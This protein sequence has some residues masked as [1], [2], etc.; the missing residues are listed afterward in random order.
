MIEVK[1]GNPTNSLL[2]FGPS[3]H[4]AIE[5]F[6]VACCY[7][8]SEAPLDFLSSLYG[9]CYFKL[10][11]LIQLSQFNGVGASMVKWT[12]K[13][14]WYTKIMMFLIKGLKVVAK[15]CLNGKFP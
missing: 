4:H 2:Y 14:F 7:V 9:I 10:S 1:G 5:W 11:S 15:C 6:H 3:P 12:Q 8:P 13:V